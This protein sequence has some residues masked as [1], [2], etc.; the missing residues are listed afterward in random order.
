[1]KAG[2]VRCPECSKPF[3][4]VDP[5]YEI[6]EDRGGI[7]MVTEAITGTCEGGHEVSAE[8]T[9]IGGRTLTVRYLGPAWSPRVTTP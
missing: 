7:I 3:R 5:E 8:L 4:D 6:G 9:R 1:M 2:L